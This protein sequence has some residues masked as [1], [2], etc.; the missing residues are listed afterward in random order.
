MRVRAKRV[1]GGFLIPIIEGLEN[2]EELEVEIL[3]NS[4][5]HSNI[6]FTDE[7]VESNWKE[8]LLNANRRSSLTDDDILPQAY[9]EYKDDKSVSRY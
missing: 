5:Y 2:R 1:E 8:I 6:Y 7:Y 9:R 4:D 3:E